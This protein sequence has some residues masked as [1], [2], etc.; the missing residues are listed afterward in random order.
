[1]VSGLH[2]APYRVLLEQIRA[3]RRAA[4]VTQE[5]L[6]NRLGADQSFVSKY[7][8]GERRL[9]VVELRSICNALELDLLT[10]LSEFERELKARG[11]A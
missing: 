11:L 4:D 8:R 1:V 7:E 9:D 6:A 2:G 5:E 10:F 3:A